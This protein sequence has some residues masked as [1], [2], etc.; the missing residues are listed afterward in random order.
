MITVRISNYDIR[1]DDE[2]SHLI[3]AH[4]WMVRSCPAGY[5][6][7][8]RSEKK[9]QWKFLHREIAGAK[10][11]RN[12]VLFRDGDWTNC[13]M[14]N[15]R[16]CD[17][18]TLTHRKRFMVWFRRLYGDGDIQ[19]VEIPGVENI[20]EAIA[21]ATLETWGPFATM[22][23]QT[24]KIIWRN[25]GTAKF[26]GYAD[27]LALTGRLSVEAWELPHKEYAGGGFKQ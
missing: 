19:P 23:G 18:A 17:G 10:T 14:E 4:R 7:A 15:L 1:I 8:R 16:L 27:M 6:V 22:D 2:F 21:R 20:S 13:T 5:R 12:L 25:P 9:W 24:G 11:R 26:R 3:T